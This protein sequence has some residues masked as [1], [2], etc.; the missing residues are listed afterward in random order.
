MKS[1][2]AVTADLGAILPDRTRNALTRFARHVPNRL[3]LA[4]SIA[5]AAQFARLPMEHH[6]RVGRR[7]GDIDFVAPSLDALPASLADEFICPHVHGDVE[8]GRTLAQFVHHQ[9]AIRIDVFRVM[10]HAL[11]RAEPM[12]LGPLSIALLSLEDQAARAASL[13]M[14][15][16]RDGSVVAK[17]LRDF[18]Q[19]RDVVSDRIDAVWQEYR[20]ASEPLRFVDAA[21]EIEAAARS[22]PERLLSPEFNRNPNIACRDCKASGVFRPAEPSRIMQ[23][24]GYW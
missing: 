13:C 19:L 6:K 24:L 21:A 9:D 5:M 15:L 14:K 4:G 17:H 10:G 2:K 18:L 1:G 12:Q 16:V 20:R 23:I 11:S 3:A 7:F 22:H 8:A